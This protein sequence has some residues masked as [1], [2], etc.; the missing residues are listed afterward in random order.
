MKK[1]GARIIATIIIMKMVAVVASISLRM[2]FT[3]SGIES[4]RPGKYELSIPSTDCSVP[5]TVA[6]LTMPLDTH[7][8]IKSAHTAEAPTVN[9]LITDLEKPRITPL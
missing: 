6:L 4:T 8:T 2:G 7:I 3:I 9:S 5:P 1:I